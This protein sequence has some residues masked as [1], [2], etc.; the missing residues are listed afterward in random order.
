MFIGTPALAGYGIS[1]ASHT[2]SSFY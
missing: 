2:A 1:V